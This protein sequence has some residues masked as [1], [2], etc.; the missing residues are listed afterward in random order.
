MPKS[1]KQTGYLVK[2]EAFIP[3][4]MTRLQ[5]LTDLQKV[6]GKIQ[7]DLPGAGASI[8]PTRR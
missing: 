8:T 7:E 5:T 2:I 4:D 3:S 6:V 1:Q